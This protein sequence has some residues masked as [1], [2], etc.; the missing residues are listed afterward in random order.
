[1]KKMIIFLLALMILLP[2]AFAEPDLSSLSFSSLASLRNQIMVEMMT[3]DEW[4]E[5]TVPAGTYCVGEH[6]PSGHWQI[7][8]APQSYCYVTIGAKLE[9][10]GKEIVYGSDGYYH[11]ALAGVDSGLSDRG[12][13]STVDLALK[14]G[15]YIYIERSF[16]TFSPYAGIPDFG[17][18]FK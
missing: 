17:F 18:T 9:G 1:M 5:V 8:C 2:S 6:I 4:Q 16:V 12:Y 13:P 10:N 11:I 7:T 15:M 14:D 3:R